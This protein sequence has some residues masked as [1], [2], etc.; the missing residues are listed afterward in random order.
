MKSAELAS[1]KPKSRDASATTATQPLSFIEKAGY[2]GADAAA[3]FVFMTMILF[4]STFYTEVF[5]FDATVAAAI[6]LWPRLWDA[7]A[8]PIVGI[9]A[10]RTNT[11][12]GKF[13]PWVIGTAIPWCV[14]MIMAYST[15]HGLSKH[16]LVF[17]AAIT[18]T[19]LMSIYSMNNMPYAALG[20]VM[21]GDINER[22]RLNSYRFIAVNA[23]QFIVG[24]FTM[25][26]VTKL[27]AK[28][29][30]GAEVVL[31]DKQYGWQWT[32]TIW[33][34]VCLV[35]FIITFVSTRERIKP[36]S[37]QTRPP[38]QDFADLVKNH[39][40]WIMFF[41]TLVHFCILAFRGGAQY[42]YYMYYADKPAMYD[43][44]SKLGLVVPSGVALPDNIFSKL[45]ETLGY[46][47]HGDRTNIA[48]SNA[49]AVFFSIISMTNT[50]VTIII[51]LLSAPLARI[52]GKKAVAATGFGLST[53]NAFAFFLLPKTSVT[54]MFLLTVTGAIVYAPTI[55]LVWAIYA[56]VADYSEWK[57]GHRF[58]G[59]VFAT[60]GFGLK[61]GLALGGASLLW[62]LAGF[63]SYHSQGIP[64]LAKGDAN[65]VPSLL[66]VPALVQQLNDTNNAVSEFV[67]GQLS[68]Q[69][70][71]ALASYQDSPA[72]QAA[73][74]A[75]L[76]PD[77]NKLVAGPS[78][79]DAKRFANIKLDQSKEWVSQLDKLAAKNEML[80]AFDL[81]CLN[82][83]LLDDA[84]PKII[85]ANWHQTEKATEGFRF[86]YAVV[87]SIL[88][89]I[90]TILLLC[91]PLGKR[92]T[93]QMADELAA[94]RL[95]AQA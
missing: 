13:R 62:I 87:V 12:W 25:P 90:C 57:T 79:H 33:A 51:I 83:A 67:K 42:D 38:K 11:R 54:G 65:H 59:T 20:G 34:V 58:T 10:D 39:P 3:N 15:P 81:S 50:G 22:A 94:R 63:F 19:L 31:A 80:E 8:D 55:A 43:F 14:V 24:G 56:D 53:L 2:S 6:L 21:T 9:L 75:S 49:A 4:Q 52:F 68:G 40:W 92:I 23:A 16:A 41:M 64:E 26:L 18:N 72:N 29:A 76:L 48:G 66:N 61:S 88:F 73:I 44:L 70:K 46:I 1:D 36:I 7:I 28:H 71:Q 93:L 32:M 95:K 91:Y 47:V 35:L 82:R 86:C 37:T 78:I 85:S 77:L 84:Y 74:E 69:T 30:N 89:G 17:Y 60:I 27:A 5:G 45:G